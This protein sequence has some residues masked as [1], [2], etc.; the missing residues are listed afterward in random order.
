MSNVRKVEKCERGEG[1]V[2]SPLKR[3]K[4]IFE[5][6]LI[7]LSSNV[8]F[9]SFVSDVTSTFSLEFPF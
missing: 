8:L 2:K 4:I 1:G 6:P 9:F 7:A 3:C 5:Q